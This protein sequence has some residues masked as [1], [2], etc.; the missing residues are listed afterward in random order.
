MEELKRTDPERWKAFVTGGYASQVD[1]GAFVESVADCLQGLADR[2]AGRRIAVFCHGGVINAWSTT[3]LGIPPRL[4][5][6]ASYTSI[7]RFLS[8][9]TGERSIE[10][11]NEVAHLRA[12]EG[13]VQSRITR[14]EPAK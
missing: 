4:F 1:F 6:D 13:S 9:S 11:L 2:N 8:A 7:S 10:S 12:L 5:F 3:V 14:K